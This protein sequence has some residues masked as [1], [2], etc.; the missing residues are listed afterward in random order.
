M[1]QTICIDFDGV[2]HSYKSGWNGA[3]N[4][5]DKPVEGAFNTINDYLIAGFKVAI[6]SSRSHVSGG[7]EAIQ[8]W[9]HKYG[10]LHTN[11]LMFPFEKPPASIYIDDR[12]FLFQ[13]T[14]PSI[15]YINNFKPWNKV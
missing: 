4:I 12:A 11:E 6:H 1:K 15:E 7:V 13:G 14:F 3:L 2:I 10:F 9:F 5:D 8:H